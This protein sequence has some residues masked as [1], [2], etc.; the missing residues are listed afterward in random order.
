M[1]TIK[2]QTVLYF[3]SKRNYFGTTVIER[4]YIVLTRVIIQTT[5]VLARIKQV[6]LRVTDHIILKNT[7]LRNHHTWH[8]EDLTNATFNVGKI[9]G[10]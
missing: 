10:L 2:F 6:F 8:F 9:V 1:F 4:N 7:K 3:F 5:V